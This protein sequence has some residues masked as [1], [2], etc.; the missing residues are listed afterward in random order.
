MAEWWNKY[1]LYFPNLKYNTQWTIYFQVYGTAGSMAY[2]TGSGEPAFVN[3]EQSAENMFTP[4][5]SSSMDFEIVETT[6]D[7]LIEFFSKERY[8]RVRAYNGGTLYWTGWV[9][10][11]D[12]SSLDNV[13]PKKFK[14]TASCGL[15]LLRDRFLFDTEVTAAQALKEIATISQGKN[16]IIKYLKLCLEFIDLD[17]P[18]YESFDII[19]DNDALKIAGKYLEGIYIDSFAF[20]TDRVDVKYMSYFE[21]L[22]NIISSYGC[23]IYQKHG[24]WYLNSVRQL[25][26]DEI[27]YREYSSA[28]AYVTIHTEDLRKTMTGSSGSPLIVPIN[29]SLYKSHDEIY[30]KLTNKVTYNINSN[31][32]RYWK[33]YTKNAGTKVWT[34]SDNK[35]RIRSGNPNNEGILYDLGLIKITNQSPNALFKIQLSGMML[36][37]IYATLYLRTTDNRLFYFQ[38]DTRQFYNK[39]TEEWEWEHT[40]V[41]VTDPNNLPWWDGSIRVDN[42]GQESSNTGTDGKI[43]VVKEF[44]QSIEANVDTLMD[45]YGASIENAHLYFRITCPYIRDYPDGTNYTELITQTT[46][47]LFLDLPNV[48]ITYKEFDKASNE[49]VMKQSEFKGIEKTNEQF[50]H[51]LPLYDYYTEESGHETKYNLNLINPDHILPKLTYTYEGGYYIPIAEYTKGTDISTHLLEKLICEDI[52]HFYSQKRLVLDGTIMGEIDFGHTLNYGSKRY[53]ID[54]MLLN[55]KMSNQTLHLVQIMAEEGSLLLETGDKVLLETG[56]EILL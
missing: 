18:L 23:R 50:L 15:N 33:Q 41:E 16:S 14:F 36:G 5:I 54:R 42:Y 2:L 7:S 25:M 52:F 12:Y 35:I 6:D 43:Y 30:K 22:E 3:Y 31:L 20:M 11:T 48:A 40:W 1:C 9:N 46:A 47:R 8:A 32:I 55:I 37:T 29:H 34:F 19:P 4:V 45:L 53:M 24:R 17:I 13:C 27:T 44:S 10:P 49:V 28:F 26:D 51:S 38:H 39:I 21:I 56:D